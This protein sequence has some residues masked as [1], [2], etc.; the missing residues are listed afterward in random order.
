MQRIKLESSPSSWVLISRHNQIVFVWNI[1]YS[2][3]VNVWEILDPRTF[4][5]FFAIKFIQ[6]HIAIMSH[7]IVDF[8]CIKAI[9]LKLIFYFFEIIKYFFKNFVS[10][11]NLRYKIRKK[12]FCRS[13]HFTLKKQKISNIKKYEKS[14]LGSF[15]KVFYTILNV[16]FL[17]K[18][19]ILTKP[20]HFHE[21]LTQFF[22]QFF[23]WNQSCQQ[24]KIP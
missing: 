6:D 23:S 13:V 2:F 16:K 21:F 15:S 18:N 5:H 9:L 4:S 20:Q 1:R 19:S 12:G 14:T 10:Y 3:F 8:G 17:Y 7:F 11:A 22:W 24:L